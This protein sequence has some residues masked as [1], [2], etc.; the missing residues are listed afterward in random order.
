MKIAY[1]TAQIPWGRAET[2][3]LEELLEVKRQEIDFLII[4]RKPPKE[5]FYKEA[6]DLVD[7]SIRL[8]LINGKTII[9]FFCSLITRLSFWRV[10]VDILRYSRNLCTLI[11]NLAVL[12]KGIY[13]SNILKRHKVDHIHVHWGATTATIG[14]VVS[15]ITNIS[16][17]FT[18]H[19]CGIMLNNMLKE[20]VRSAKFVRCIS[21]HGKSELLQIV[22]EQYRKKVKVIHVGIK[23]PDIPEPKKKEN[24]PEKFKIVTPASF[25]EVKGHEYLIKTCSILVKKNIRNFQCFFYGEGPLRAK[26]ES[27]V[28]KEGLQNYIRM[29]GIVS[30]EKL[31]KLYKSRRVDL[32]VLS[33]INTEKGSHE[34]IPVSLMEAMAYKIPVISTD[35]GGV[36]E[37]LS[38]GAGIMVEER[39]PEQL[40]KAIENLLGNW[41]LRNKT[42]ENGYQCVRKEFNVTTVTK[43]LLKSIGNNGLEYKHE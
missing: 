17:S 41:E 20:K 27:L 31:V 21:E 16:W 33:S 6:E 8:S 7:N 34:G 18:L 43:K 28:K 32:V 26:L 38:N 2:F 23:I 14:Y 13:M 24:I 39:S 30:H 4:P 22:G 5:I 1:I 12:P 3:I 40:A 19:R 25:F 11:K 35:T 15:C 10:L 42:G 29:P 36:S 37:L 9:G